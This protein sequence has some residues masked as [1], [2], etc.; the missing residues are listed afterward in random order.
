MIDAAQAAEYLDTTLGV[1]VPGF[2]LDAAIETVGAREQQ[3]VDAGYTPA[4]ILLLQCM[5]VALLAAAGDPRRIASQGAPSGAS[6]SFRY[7][8][9]SLSMLRR[10]LAATDSAGILADVVGDDPA[11]GTLLMVVS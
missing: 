1:T 4:N 2:V 5:A 3:M 6:R 11:F 7:S 9:K 10:Q 8:E